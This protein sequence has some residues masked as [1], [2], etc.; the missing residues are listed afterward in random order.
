MIQIMFN[1]P[2]V[3]GGK[4]VFSNELW[5]SNP[6]TARFNSSIGTEKNDN[7]IGVITRS[8]TKYFSQILRG[9]YLYTFTK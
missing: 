1:L 3:G 6:G 4:K 7:Q 5:M 9:L 8:A 2:A